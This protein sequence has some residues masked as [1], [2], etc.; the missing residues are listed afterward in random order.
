[1]NQTECKRLTVRINELDKI[2][3]N[4]RVFFPLDG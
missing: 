4:Y 3:Q 1:M 2:Y